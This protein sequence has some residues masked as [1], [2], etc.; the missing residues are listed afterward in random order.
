MHWT[1]YS[2]CCNKKIRRISHQHFPVVRQ[3][4]L[5]Y[6]IPWWKSP[7]LLFETAA[8][9]LCMASAQPTSSSLLAQVWLDQ[10]LSTLRGGS[11]LSATLYITEPLELY[12][13]AKAFDI[14]NLAQNSLRYS[15]GYLPATAWSGSDY[16]RGLQ[17][18]PGL[19][20]YPNLSVA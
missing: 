11:S 8:P 9:M 15:S 14:S 16:D 10:S 3:T 20:F 1:I 17:I 2:K 5:S 4:T 13:N 19:T 6:T 18:C 7:I 12:S